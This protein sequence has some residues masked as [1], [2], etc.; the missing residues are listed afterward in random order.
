MIPLG[1]LLGKNFLLPEIH[2]RAEHQGG[3]DGAFPK[4]PFGAENEGQGNAQQHQSDVD[5]LTEF[6][7]GNAQTVGDQLDAA[8]HGSAHQMGFQHQS[9]AEGA[10]E[11]CTHRHQQ[12]DG[13][14]SEGN[15]LQHGIQEKV[16]DGS[17]QCDVQDLKEFCFPEILLLN[18]NLPQEEAA[19]EQDRQGAHF[20]V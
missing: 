5:F 10:E 17:T 3:D 19:V 1:N 12:P 18:G 2:S 20:Y 13:V 7:H 9:A 16:Q 6:A 4:G 15:I 8:F 14:E 11:E